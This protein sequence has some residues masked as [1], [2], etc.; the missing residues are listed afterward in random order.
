MKRTVVG[1]FGL[2]SLVGAGSAGL[3]FGHDYFLAD[4]DAATVDA[5]DFAR[6][7]TPTPIPLAG[8]AGRP[9]A[10]GQSVSP[11]VQSRAR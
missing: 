5:A 4:S 2:L 1:I 3:Y 11:D 8:S 10:G 6:D 7:L 9:R